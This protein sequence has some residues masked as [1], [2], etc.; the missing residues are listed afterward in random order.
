MRK[1]RGLRF[2]DI[3]L[4]SLPPLISIHV[5]IYIGNLTFCLPVVYVSPA[6]IISN[7]LFHIYGFHIILT[8]NSDYFLKQRQPADLCNGEVLISLLQGLKS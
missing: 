1:N 6:S 3:R 2:K 8:V 4:L 7:S 5:K